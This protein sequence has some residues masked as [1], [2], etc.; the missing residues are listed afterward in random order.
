MVSRPFCTTAPPRNDDDR[1]RNAQPVGE[2]GELVGDMIAVG[3]FADA[4]AVGDLPR[5]RWGSRAIR[6]STTVRVRPKFIAIGLDSNLALAS[7]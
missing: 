5:V 7:A 4:D 3:V 1:R 6:R 2:D